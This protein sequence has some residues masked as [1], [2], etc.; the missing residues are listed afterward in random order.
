MVDR[1]A[2]L[3]GHF[4]VSARTFQSGPLCGVNALDGTDP[5]GQ[6]HLIKDGEVEVYQGNKLALHIQEPSLLFYPRPTPHRFVT[7][8]TRGADFVCSHISFAGGAANP[9][10]N[11]LPECVC[12]PLARLPGSVPV[13]TLLFTE[14]EAR[15][16]GRQAML[17]RLFEVLLIQVLRQLME[18]GSARVG[19]LAGLTHPQLRRAIVAIHE[20]P[21]QDWKVE[22]LA[23]RAGMSRSVFSN[24]FREAVGETPAAYLQRWR[25]GLVQKWLQQGRSLKLI[26][27]EAGYGSESALSR[28]FK[29]QSGYSPKEWLRAQ[30]MA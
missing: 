13:L 9:I 1:L 10:L 16:C 27:E 25:I 11:A 17:D 2:A 24:E 12:F 26:A 3:L 15:Y 14:A 29:A 20:A 19:L 7:E 8:P 21:E 28:A 4:S 6:L 22:D 5:N 30:S 23:A 18:D